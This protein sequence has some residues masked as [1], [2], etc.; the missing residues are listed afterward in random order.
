MPA[1]NVNFD[2]LRK[3]EVVNQFRQSACF[4]DLFFNN[5]VNA[6]EVRAYFWIPTGTE[7]QAN[8]F[9]D[10][11]IKRRMHPR[12]KDFVKVI[13]V[14]KNVDEP[15]EADDED[16]DDEGRERWDEGDVR[17][18]DYPWWCG[19]SID[20][21]KVCAFDLFV[22]LNLYRYP[23]EH[24]GFVEMML[25]TKQERKCTLDEAFVVAHE[26]CGNFGHSLQS[27]RM[28]YD[29]DKRWKKYRFIEQ[30]KKAAL[31]MD[32]ELQ[33]PWTERQR[34]PASVSDYFTSYPD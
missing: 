3:G 1:Y 7:K 32:A 13:P 12:V 4:A 21:S 5:V 22:L 16:D 10:Q 29:T 30:W 28:R 27:S 11:F 34:K 15:F 18:P 31:E 9:R 6:D 24:T 26:I 2:L 19:V 25:K 23:Q 14:P 20:V 17:P 8:W 33:V